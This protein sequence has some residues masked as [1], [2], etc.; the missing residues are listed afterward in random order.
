L[1]RSN[2][3]STRDLENPS[4][5]VHLKRF[6]TPSLTLKF[7]CAGKLNPRLLKNAHW[8]ALQFA[9][10]QIAADQQNAPA[11]TAESLR[12][13][14]TELGRPHRR[15]WIGR[16]PLALN[17][18]RPVRWMVGLHRQPS[19]LILTATGSPA[20]LRA[21]AG[22]LAFHAPLTRLCCPARGSTVSRGQTPQA[23]AALRPP[24]ANAVGATFRKSCDLR[25]VGHCKA[26]A[27]YLAAAD[28]SLHY[29]LSP[30]G[31][32]RGNPT[33]RGRGRPFWALKFPIGFS[34]SSRGR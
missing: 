23:P 15:W 12:G 8:C 17:A 30:P 33:A 25:H 34:R 13:N 6:S 27:A 22:L 19:Q 5:S 11:A 20:A 4:A 2:V 9:A 29:A 32:G 26:V 14:A 3:C 10:P 21:L 18:P 24:S 31:P 28:S 7:L 1:P 16:E